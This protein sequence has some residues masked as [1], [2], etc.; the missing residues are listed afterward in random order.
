MRRKEPFRVLGEVP[1]RDD[2]SPLDIH[3]RRAHGHDGLAGER[4]I[5]GL[6]ALVVLPAMGRRVD[7]VAAA[8]RR[9]D[10]IDASRNR[11]DA[12]AI[13]KTLPQH[14]VEVPRLLVQVPVVL[15]ELLP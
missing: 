1:Q 12:L 10:A 13:M 14:L 8:W 2:G 11:A 7:G 9:A 6:L 3:H 15:R 5:V 4:I